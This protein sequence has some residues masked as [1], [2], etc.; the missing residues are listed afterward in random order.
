MIEKKLAITVIT[1]HYPYQSKVYTWNGIQVHPLNG[2]NSRI[3]KWFFLKVKL[4]RC[5]SKL[6]VADPI[7]IIHSF[8]LQEA[9]IWSLSWAKEKSIPVISSA[10]G[11]DVLEGNKYLNRF[12]FFESNTILTL[13]KFQQHE[14]L[15]TTGF[16]SDVF[17][18]GT[19]DLSAFDQVEKSVD[20]IGV[21]NLIPLKNYAYFIELCA[22]L[23]R[24]NPQLI[25]K[26]IGVGSEKQHLNKLI[27]QHGLMDTVELLGKL[28]YSET[29]RWISKSKVLLH[30]S[31]FEG[32]GMI[33]SEAKALQ[34]H[35]VAFPVGLAY[36]LEMDTYLSGNIQQDVLFIQ[37]LLM[38]NPP[39]KELIHCEIDKLVDIYSN[40]RKR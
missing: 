21:G 13:T 12:H 7:T 16:K 26:L 17:G 27:I 25:V 20:I 14:L 37:E 35:I 1:L 5:L 38:K 23:K 4:H 2:R 9:S 31:K 28:D 34:S 15:K 19:G 36:D 8:W 39:A 24:T 11:Q 40:P 6:H 10:M 18:F 30:P 32:F 22:A 3:K 33:F 29:L